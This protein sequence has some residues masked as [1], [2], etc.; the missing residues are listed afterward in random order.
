MTESPIG[1]FHI[2][3]FA[4]ASSFTNKQSET[5]TA[6]LPLAKLFDVLEAKYPGIEEKVLTS[7][8]V[9]INAEY[10]DV[11][12]ERIKLRDMEAA[13]D[14]QS[15]T[16][17]FICG[18]DEVAIIPPDLNLDQHNGL[19]K[20]LNIV[21]CARLEIEACNHSPAL[22]AMTVDPENG[23]PYA[24][25][26]TSVEEGKALDTTQTAV[27]ESKLVPDDS[28]ESLRRGSY[29]PTRLQS[30]LTIISC[31]IANF[32]DG[33]QN[34]LANPTNVIFKKLLGTKGYPSE[35]QTRISNSLLIGAIL[36]VLALGYTSDMFSRRAGLLF[37]SGLVAVGT[38]MSTLAL[39]VYPTRNMLWYF[40]VVRG[41]A[42]FG[43]G[44]EYPPSAAAGI[45]ESD[46]FKR[47]YRGPIF[48]SFTTLMATSA[49]PIQMIVY[50][51]C[52]IASNENLPVTF[53]A[54]YSIATILPVIIMILRFFMTDSTLFHYSNFKRQ[55]RPV[56]F[57]LLLL[58]R[59][60]W[61]L[62]TTSLAFFLYDFINFPNSIMSSTII[63]SLVKDHNIR[64]TAIWQVIL[65]ALPVP[66]VIVGAWLTNAIGRRY[67]GILGF[68]GYMVLGFVIG[69]TFPTLAKNMPA[70]VVLYGLLQALG[71][72]GPGATIGLISSES[73]P[74]AMRGMGYS[75]ATAFGRTGAAVGTQCFTPLQEAAGKQSTFYL[76][77]A[78][79]ILGM[80][81]YWFLP[82]SSQL[83]LEEED[84]ELSVYL[85]E[86]GFPMEK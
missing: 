55:K 59:Y 19:A 86:N 9:S 63:N 43:V 80:I 18:G 45:E 30:N 41:I 60:R 81:V 77:G 84:R 62:F 70:F 32:S 51:I 61:R 4:S 66:G 12:E 36:G 11:E 38:L 65:G 15:R 73:F 16:L 58:K 44:G 50:L 2:H 79:A 76:A 28:P 64:T 35:M 1:T 22:I 24:R 69:G 56:K 7:C 21:V 17:A 23:L 27:K 20:F 72:M 74:T 33:F 29:R 53:H 42:G 71:H 48:V 3:Y 57:Y 10:V 6:P 46:D 31:Y 47:K 67:T 39:Q 83:D 75:V 40:V 68:A 54:L 49:A 26:N 25:A 5:L 13:R 82:E 78:V 34:S 14:G 8:G 52:L 85:A 37:T